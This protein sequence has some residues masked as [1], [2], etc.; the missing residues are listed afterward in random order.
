MGESGLHAE[1][2]APGSQTLRKR[3][4]ILWAGVSRVTRK[5]VPGHI[6]GA[7]WEAHVFVNDKRISRSYSVAKF[8]ESAAR[9]AATLRRML[10]LLEYQKWSPED[11]DPLEF[12]KYGDLFSGNADYQDSE[13]FE[14]RESRRSKNHN[15]SGQ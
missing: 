7:A 5:P 4:S 14:A 10:W 1:Q 3:K 9:L 6:R 8:G 13:D 15:A 2:P 11:G 12:L